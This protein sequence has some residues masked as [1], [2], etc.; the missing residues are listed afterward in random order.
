MKE[1]DENAIRIKAREVAKEIENLGSPF[2]PNEAFYFGAKYAE[3]IFLVKVQ[4][5]ESDVYDLTK[6]LERANEKT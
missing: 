2:G 5:L 4:E 1:L 3:R 6:R